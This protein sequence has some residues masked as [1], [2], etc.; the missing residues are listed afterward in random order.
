MM[1]STLSYAQT[2]TLFSDDNS[3]G[4][5]GGPMIEFSNINGTLV[6]D[7]GGGGALVINDFFVGGYGLGTEGATVE[8]DGEPYDIGFGHGG[9]WFGYTF[10]QH[11]LIH[12]YSS[13]RVG[14]GSAKLRQDGDK[15]YSD[16]LLALAPEAGIELNITDWFKL[17]VSGGYRYVSG[18]D[19]L[20]ALTSEDFTG[21]F[22]ALT[23][24][25]G[26]FGD[27]D[28]YGHKRGDIDDDDDDF[29]F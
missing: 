9:L 18:V 13:F 25:F 24:R 10:N 12:I 20:P 19:D 22:G 27:Y 29:D 23:F 2:E 7:V 3:Y 6:G 4:G 17:G 1:L 16:N 26:G 15:K 8:F 5:F 11:K 14:W 28:D 21:M